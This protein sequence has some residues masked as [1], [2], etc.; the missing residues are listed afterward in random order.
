MAVA[1][2]LIVGLLQRWPVLNY[3][4]LA[5]IVYVSARM[6]VDGAEQVSHLMT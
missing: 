4:G 5:L 3:I 6:I 1:A 2:N